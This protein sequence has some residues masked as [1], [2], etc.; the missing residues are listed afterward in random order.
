[1]NYFKCENLMIGSSGSGNCSRYFEDWVIIDIMV[2]FL[3]IGICRDLNSKL[4]QN[5][6]NNLQTE[7]LVTTLTVWFQW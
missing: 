6:W 1:M 5:V 2:H 7:K 4:T 3:T